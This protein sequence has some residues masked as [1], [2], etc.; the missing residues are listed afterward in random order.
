MNPMKTPNQIDYTLTPQRFKSSVNKP[1]T[2][3]F[4]GTDVGSDHDLVIMT[5][6][7]RLQKNQKNKNPQIR[8]DIEKLQD[9][10]T[11]T[12]FKAT[13]GGRFAPLNFLEPNI[14]NLINSFGT[15]M[16]DTDKEVL[17]K[18]RMKRQPWVSNDV[19]KLCD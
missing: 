16:P 13:I 4:P 1:K 10:N 2:R 12:H 14:N 18:P 7:L 9:P 3:T 17:G 11:A 5:K 8:F 6:N 15:A 19:P